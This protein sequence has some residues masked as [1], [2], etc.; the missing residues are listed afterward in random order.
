MTGR[1]LPWTVQTAFSGLYVNLLWM[2][3][4]LPV[5]TLPAATGALVKSVHDWRDDGHRPTALSFL[6]SMRAVG[7]PS[8]VLGLAVGGV[9]ALA[10]ANALIAVHFGSGRRVFLALMLAVLLNALVLSVFS[11]SGL[12]AGQVGAWGS[13]TSSARLAV[14]SPLLA[15]AAGLALS[16][17][18]V[19]VAIYPVALLFVP[20][21]VTGVIEAMRRRAQS[22]RAS[23]PLAEP[24]EEC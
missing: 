21:M 3:A 4:S 6:R 22:R 14:S 7:W 20:V 8:S 12:A 2:V 18:V 1:R 11:L 23:A 9:L 10:G 16:I 19:L 5:V 17:G 13:V 24:I 15:G